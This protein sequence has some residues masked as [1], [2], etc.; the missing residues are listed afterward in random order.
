MQ[1]DNN[2]LTTGTWDLLLVNNGND[3]MINLNA[4]VSE[5][6]DSWIILDCD[7]EEGLSIG[8]IDYPQ[9]DIYVVSCD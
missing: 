4:A 2:I 8:S 3:L 5:Y 9:A 6:N 7:E 1:T